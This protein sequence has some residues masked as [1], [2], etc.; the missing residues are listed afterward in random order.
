MNSEKGFIKLDN[1][2]WAVKKNPEKKF[3]IGDFIFVK[4]KQKGWSLKQYP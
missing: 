4:R 1:M 3:S 2:K